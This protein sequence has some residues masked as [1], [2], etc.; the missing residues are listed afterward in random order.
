MGMGA[1]Y[2]NPCMQPP[3]YPMLSSGQTYPGAPA[4]MQTKEDKTALD[5]Y[6]QDYQKYTDKLEVDC[7]AN[8]EKEEVSKK[9]LERSSFWGDICQYLFSSLLGIG[10]VIIAF[11]MVKKS[12]LEV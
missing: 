9:S 6:N 12:E 7:R 8:M 2:Y 11:R 1:P 3:M 4:V 5:K 10:A